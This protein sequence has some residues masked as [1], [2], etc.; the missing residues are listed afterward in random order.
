MKTLNVVVGV[1]ALA[2]IL[3]AGVSYYKATHL[4]KDIGLLGS[5]QNTSPSHLST[6]GGDVSNQDNTY[7]F[8]DQGIEVRNNAYFDNTT[9][10]YGNV[11]NFSILQPPSSTL[12]IGASG[13][14]TGCLEM[15]N[16]AGTGIVYVTVASSSI[17]ATTTKPPTCL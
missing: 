10:M 11:A 6:A 17:T 1:V 3:L 13:T 14:N 15:G 12:K 2:A 7:F 5:V 4:P 9:T 8:G 16:A